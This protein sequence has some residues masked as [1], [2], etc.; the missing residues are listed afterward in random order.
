M[1]VMPSESPV[2]P[3]YSQTPT[4][5]PPAPRR[6]REV[7]SDRVT[8]AI[9]RALFGVIW[10]TFAWNSTRFILE[11][12]PKGNWVYAVIAIAAVGNLILFGFHYALWIV[13]FQN[14]SIYKN[15]EV[16]TGA[17]VS[18][19]EYRTSRGQLYHL[20]K[21]SFRDSFSG[22]DFE[23]EVS[24]G[25]AAFE[26]AVAGQQITV[27]YNRRKPA[28]SVAYEFGNIVIALEPPR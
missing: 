18:K 11:V 28:Q 1:A 27:L 20:V 16:T 19:K 13:P 2:L 12:W 6:V 26:R 22:R 4:P 23:E 10:I 24:V 21:Y 25:Y 17:V 5:L 8:R 14:L 3:G 9:L 15:G 7:V